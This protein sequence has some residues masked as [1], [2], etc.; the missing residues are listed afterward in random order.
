[1]FWSFWRKPR[2]QRFRRVLFQVHLW[3]G[4]LLGLYF[5]VVGL[6]GSLVV[7]KKEI[8]RAMIPRLVRVPEGEIRASFQVMYDAVAAQYPRAKISNAWLYQQPGVSW[9]FR[10][11]APDGRIQVYVDPYRGRIIG[12]DRYQEKFL[13]WVYDLHVNLLAGK[14]GLLVNGIG[15]FCLIAMCITGMVI[16]WPGVAVWRQ[17]FRYE[18]RARWKRQ[19]YDLHK[20]GGFWTLGLL[21]L[22]ALTGAYWAFPE[23]YERALAA[24]TGGPGKQLA[25]RITPE[26][27]RPRA[28]LDLVLAEAMRGI[29]E[30]EATL[31]RFAQKP[32]ETHS[33]KKKLPGDWRTTGDNTVY[34]HP[35]SAGTVFVDYHR[36]RPLGVRLQRDIYGL[37]FG[38]FWGHPTRVLW[39]FTGLAP[40]LLFVTGLLM[41]WNRVLVKK[42][43]QRPPRR[44]QS[45]RESLWKPQLQ[46]EGQD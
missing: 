2:E 14:T 4:L 23:S 11:A 17:G 10:L 29:P 40:G 6:S 19:N 22:L 3:A 21:F 13:D 37:H 28:S 25:P 35:H 24:M 31:F 18:W 36:D 42:Q 5:L 27:N 43:W 44:A 46:S 8:E 45:Q 15:G 12:E 20:L 30:G 33:I 9:S 41:Y 32:D 39:I 1:M 38:T 34:I 7:Y 26:P 16:W